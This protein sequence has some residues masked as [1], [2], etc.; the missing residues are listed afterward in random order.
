M[1]PFDVA[2][3]LNEMPMSCFGYKTPTEA[4]RAMNVE[5]GE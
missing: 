3:A 5:S 2:S 4:F 1:S